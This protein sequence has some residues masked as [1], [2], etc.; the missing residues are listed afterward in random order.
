G[1]DLR[2]CAHAVTLS[3]RSMPVS[4]L[5]WRSGKLHARQRAFGAIGLVDLI[6]DDV[7]ASF[8]LVCIVDLAGH[9]EA[10]VWRPVTP[11][12]VL[13]R[14]NGERLVG[15]RRAWLRVDPEADLV[16]VRVQDVA[17]IGV[18]MHEGKRVVLV[19]GVERDDHRAITYP[20]GNTG[21][22]VQDVHDL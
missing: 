5:L 6:Q 11:T 19:L 20:G 2:G 14:E 1:L 4:R 22:V 3:R 7:E 10:D 12:V 17:V 18:V 16:A 13:E 8:A 21:R 9:D 15:R